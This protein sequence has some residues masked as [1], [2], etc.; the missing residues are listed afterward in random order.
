MPKKLSTYDELFPQ[1]RQD[2][3]TN[4]AEKNAEFS[5]WVDDIKATYCTQ[6]GRRT[7]WE[8]MRDKFLFMSPMTGNSQTFYNIGIMDDARKKL[9]LIA[10]ADL[11]TFLWFW[12]QW[13]AYVRD[14]YTD[15]ITE[16][17]E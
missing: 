17:G 7:L 1:D 9:N 5:Q 16:K 11:E 14:K 2:Q 13:G 12:A 10:V 3:D 4:Q 8:E 15:K 6:H